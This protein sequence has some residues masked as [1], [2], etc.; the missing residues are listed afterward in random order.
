MDMCLFNKDRLLIKRRFTVLFVFFTALLLIYEIRLG[1]TSAPPPT[2]PLYACLFTYMLVG[3]LY[4]REEKNSASCLLISATYSR[5]D[6]M[7]SRFLFLVGLS[8]A[9]VLYCAPLL[10][11]LCTRLTFTC[12][13]QTVFW[14]C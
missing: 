8:L 7:R 6:I 4:E 14:E 10:S 13:W 11:S 2:L 5:R 9:F 1:G 12:S 3:M